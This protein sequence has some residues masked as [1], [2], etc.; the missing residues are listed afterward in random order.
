MMEC[1]GHTKLISISTKHQRN[2][3]GSVGRKEKKFKCDVISCLKQL[4]ILKSLNRFVKWQPSI[5]GPLARVT[6]MNILLYKRNHNSYMAINI[7][8]VA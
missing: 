3:V 6:C 4:L 1:L 2:E 5:S 7:V 8:V